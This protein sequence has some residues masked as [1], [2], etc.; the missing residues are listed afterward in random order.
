MWR[1]VKRWR[2]ETG[3]DRSLSTPQPTF[4]VVKQCY[5]YFLHGRSRKGEVVVYEQ[6]GKM[7]FGRL[8]EAGVSPFRMQVTMAMGTTMMIMI[9]AR[10][11]RRN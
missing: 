9:A 11:P 2:A 4:E 7:Q 10:R 8:S 6:T 5:P 1:G 3:A